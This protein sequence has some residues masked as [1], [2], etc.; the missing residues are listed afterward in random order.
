MSLNLLEMASVV[1]PLTA[2]EIRATINLFD[3]YARQGILAR[4]LVHVAVMLNNNLEQVVSV[5]SHFDEIEGI[6]RLDPLTY[7]LP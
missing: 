7:V 6:T 4:D 1:Y 2:K 5:D 3:R